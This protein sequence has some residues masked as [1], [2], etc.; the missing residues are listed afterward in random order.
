MKGGLEEGGGAG[1][2]VEMLVVISNDRS[3]T[4]R[5]ERAPRRNHRPLFRRDSLRLRSTGAKHAGVRGHMSV[6]EPPECVFFFFL[7]HLTLLKID[8]QKPASWLVNNILSIDILN[9][10]SVS[11]EAAC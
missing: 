11:L 10:A 8:E 9:A 3:C 4:P 5:G 6:P 2:E 1:G 7:S